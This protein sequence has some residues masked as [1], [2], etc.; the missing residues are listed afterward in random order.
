MISKA[1]L[2]IVSSQFESARTMFDSALDETLLKLYGRK[3]DDGSV[4]LKLN[5]HLNYTDDDKTSA[6]PVI[7]FDI[8]SAVADK[9]KLSDEIPQDCI[10]MLDDDG[11]PELRQIPGKQVTLGD[12]E[13]DYTSHDTAI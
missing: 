4:T 5:I 13:D 6:I 9:F 11:S 3:I 8:T 12:M 2:S 7:D 1:K 10:I